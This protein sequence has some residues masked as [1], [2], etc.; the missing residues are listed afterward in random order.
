MDPRVSL[1]HRVNLEIQGQQELQDPQDQEA[2]QASQEKM[3]KLEGMG[4]QEL[5][6]QLV[7]QE[8]VA[9]LACLESQAPRV[10]EVSM[11]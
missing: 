6:D 10:I 5:W 9:Y 8:N 3:V 7:L 2:Y 1:D 4:S 11:D